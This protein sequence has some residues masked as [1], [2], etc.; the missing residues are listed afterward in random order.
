M[1]DQETEMPRLRFIEERE[2]DA[3]KRALIASAE[4]TGAP[5]PRV[6]RIMTRSSAGIAW[7]KCWNSVLYEGRLPHRLKEMCRIRISVAHRCGYCSTVRSSVARAQGLDEG[8]VQ[9]VLGDLSGARLSAREK[10]AL[11]Y[12]DLFKAGDEP[13]DSD[14]VYEALRRHF[15]EDEIVELG[16]L[17][18]QTVGVGRLV[19]SLNI[20]SW[21]EACELN[22][23]LAAKA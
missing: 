12:A 3:E 9:E 17:C 10:A 15:A 7:V 22:P 13:I 2:L 23:A 8:L 18:A 11:E 21:E 14:A 6:V 20:V 5:D 19:R 16:M 1:E 4:R